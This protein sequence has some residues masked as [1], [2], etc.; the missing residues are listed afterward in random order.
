MKE[1]AAGHDEVNISMIGHARILSAD[2]THVDRSHEHEFVDSECSL[3]G[4]C[5]VVQKGGQS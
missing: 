5:D 3:V 2:Q 1:S 4:K